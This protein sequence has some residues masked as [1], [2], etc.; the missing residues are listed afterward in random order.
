[1]PESLS[2]CPEIR[3]RSASLTIYSHFISC[4]SFLLK[5]LRLTRRLTEANGDIMCCISLLSPRLMTRVTP[6]SRWQANRDFCKSRELFTLIGLKNCVAQVTACICV[7][8]R[9]K[10]RIH[11]ETLWRFLTALWDF[12]TVMR[13]GGGEINIGTCE[14]FLPLLSVKEL[15]LQGRQSTG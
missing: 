8:V 15:I 2:K 7:C 12:S 9:A 6:L 1:M 14:E 4:P 13:D 3:F 11:F 5:D 10:V